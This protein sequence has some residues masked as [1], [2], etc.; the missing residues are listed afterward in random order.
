[1]DLTVVAGAGSV[2]SNVLDYSKWIKAFL[3]A[4]G[5]VSKA[6]YRA[7][8][9]PHMFYGPRSEPTAFTGPSSY[10][11]GWET[12]VYHGY[13][14]Y[15]H[16]GGM[17]SFGSELIIFPKLNYGVI[18][19]GNTAGTSNFVQESVL[20]H[21]VDERLNISVKERFDWDTQ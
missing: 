13:Q 7:V 5:P 6:G 4:T 20:W 3:T 18:G 10:A 9:T 21:L 11:F 17:I 1:M 12:G 2:I 14:Y 8:T 19:L 16:N 15:A